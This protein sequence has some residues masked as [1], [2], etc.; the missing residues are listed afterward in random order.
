MNDVGPPGHFAFLTGIGE[1]RAVS[2]DVLAVLKSNV[3]PAEAGISELD[4]RPACLGVTVIAKKRATIDSLKQA[5]DTCP[6][7][8]LS[9]SACAGEM[10]TTC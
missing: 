2:K 4:L 8:R 7:T 10:G 5:I 1:S 6:V 9:M 3:D